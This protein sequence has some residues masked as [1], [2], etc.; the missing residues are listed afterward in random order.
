MSQASRI[1]AHLKRGPITQPQAIERY[2]CYRLAARI[3]DL[4]MAGHKISTERVGDAQ[5]ARYRLV[6]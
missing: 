6:A 4:R 1:L 2:N 5:M 3:A